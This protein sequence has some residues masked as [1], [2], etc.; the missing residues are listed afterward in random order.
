[1]AESSARN[2][3]NLIWEVVGLLVVIIVV[4]TLF[5][6]IW[7][8]KPIRGYYLMNGSETRTCVWANVDWE[9][10]LKSFCTDDVN[11]AIEAMKQLNAGL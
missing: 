6:W 9:V 8:S 2:R 4:A 10:D 5:A 3:L 7:K 1:M 11:F